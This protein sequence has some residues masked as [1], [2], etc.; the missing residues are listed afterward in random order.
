MNSGSLVGPVTFVTFSS[1]NR[2]RWC[3]FN[4][5]ANLVTSSLLFITFASPASLQHEFQRLCRTPACVTT[6]HPPRRHEAG[7]AEVKVP[8]SP[9]P[10]PLSHLFLQNCGKSA[11]QRHTDLLVGRTV[12]L[13]QT[14]CV[15]WTPWPNVTLTL[16]SFQQR[17]WTGRSAAACSDSQEFG[18]LKMCSERLRTQPDLYTDKKK[19]NQTC[20]A[21][22]SVVPHIWATD[23]NG[24]WRWQR[25]QLAA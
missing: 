7:H 17:C 23:W 10:G 15:Y 24:R 9:E 13:F 20:K 4:Q 5:K 3:S 22:L 12:I 6:V 1:S 25:P 2:Q 14:W 21:S 11:G 8:I 16:I 18:N 19:W